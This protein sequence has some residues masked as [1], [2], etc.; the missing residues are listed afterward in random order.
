MSIYASKGYPTAIFCL[1][2]NTS[3]FV[4]R[5]HYTQNHM[6]TRCFGRIEA[7]KFWGSSKNRTMSGGMPPFCP[8][9]VLRSWLNL[10]LKNVNFV[11][12]CSPSP[13]QNPNIIQNMSLKFTINIFLM[14]SISPKQNYQTEAH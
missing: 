4:L 9:S 6:G 12:P 14:L 7:Y 11:P 5:S 1:R 8:K 10:E 2:K 3:V 13:T